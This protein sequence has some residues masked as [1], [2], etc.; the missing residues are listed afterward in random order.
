M[1]NNVSR[2][3][4]VYKMKWR[5]NA[6]KLAFFSPSAFLPLSSLSKKSTIWIIE[7]KGFFSLNNSGNCLNFPPHFSLHFCANS[8]HVYIMR[9]QYYSTINKVFCSFALIFQLIM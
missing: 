3:A 7:A 5:I 1:G 8:D 4:L 2:C 6:I 9:V